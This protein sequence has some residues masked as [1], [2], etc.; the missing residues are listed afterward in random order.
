MRLRNSFNIHSFNKRV[1]SGPDVPGIT[2]NTGDPAGNEPDPWKHACPDIDISCLTW[3]G[4]GGNNQV[5]IWL[6]GK[7]GEFR[8]S[9]AT[10]PA[11]CRSP[12]SHQWSGNPIKTC[13]W[14]SHTKTENHALCYP[15]LCSPLAHLP[16]S[17]HSLWLLSKSNRSSNDK[18]FACLQTL[19]CQFVV[20]DFITFSQ[21][22][23]A[24]PMR[25]KLVKLWELQRIQE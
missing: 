25:W 18:L 17:S 6:Q 21:L 13:K 23:S 10:L 7:W 15:P 14:Y 2:L 9:T 8:C 4:V 5:L 19:G 20:S 12:F 22:F 1:H 3:R 11:L 24:P 16:H